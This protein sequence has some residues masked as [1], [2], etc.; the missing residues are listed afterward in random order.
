[1][2][3]SILRHRTARDRLRAEEGAELRRLVA[4]RHGLPERARTEIIAAI[5]RETASEARWTFVMLSPAQNHAVLS[6][7]LEHSRRPRKAVELW[8]LLFV[9]LRRDTG[10]GRNFPTIREL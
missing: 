4:E 8:A 3:A 2:A 6:W 5:D 10:S 1:M 9:H 7:L